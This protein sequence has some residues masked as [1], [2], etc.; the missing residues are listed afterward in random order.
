MGRRHAAAL[1]AA[2]ATLGTVGLFFLVPYFRENL[3]YPLGW[4]S[5]FYVWRTQV[6]PIE[7]LDRNGVVRSASPLLLAVLSRLTGQN[8][9]TLVALVPAVL[10]G[11][12]SLGASAM[13]RASLDLPV[14]WVPVIG[15]LLWLA[16]GYAG[17]VWEQF[18]NLLNSAL[19]LAG[20]G[21]A[22]AAVAWGRGAVAAGI[23]FVVAGL[24]HWQFYVFAMAVFV[25]AVVVFGRDELRHALGTVGR[26]LPRTGPL[27]AAAAVSGV[28]VGLGFLLAPFNPSVGPR[29]LGIRDLLRERFLRRAVE[30]DRYVAVPFAAAGAALLVRGSE[31][32]RPSP[33]RELFLWLMAVWTGLTLIGALAQAFGAPTAGLRLLH[34]LFPVTLLTGVF[35]WKA[36]ERATQRFSPR[37]ARFAAGAL[38]VVTVGAFGALGLSRQSRARAWVEDEAVRQAS[39]AGAYADQDVPPE[40]RVVYVVDPRRRDALTIARWRNTILSS[41]PPAEVLRSEVVV[42]D[43]ADFAGT[44]SGAAIAIAAYSPRSF[45]ELAT[46]R[47]RQ[48]APGV[49]LLQ[50]P[51]AAGPV[52]ASPPSAN[53]AFRVALP[54]A[55]LIT[56]IF[57]VGGGGWAR[58]LL[59]P[60]PSTRV[61]LSPALG[62]VLIVLSTLIWER[63]GLSLA[64]WLI[65]APPA[66]GAAAGWAVSAVRR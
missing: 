31:S 21:A 61:L 50:G 60:D 7:G 47:Q 13:A 66:I 51:R 23:L 26:R 37:I 42:G 41:I 34:Y 6:V 33:A 10:A 35:V 5:P 48:I 12:A 18:D 30:P 27:L 15:I 62:I 28:V 57:F 52:R 3:R 63:I 39:A 43:P 54:V 2:A 16:F 25:F 17:M 58:A 11:V 24:A 44:A 55:A 59:P 45:E 46:G 38:V 29:F 20:F 19:V 53:M 49:L 8:A 65:A 36:S 14:R 9:W 40:G 32:E 64:G 22:L 56:V 4:D 1:I